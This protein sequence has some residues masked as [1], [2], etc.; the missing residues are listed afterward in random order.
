MNNMQMLDRYGYREKVEGCVCVYNISNERGEGYIFRGTQCTKVRNWKFN[1][2]LY[3]TVIYHDY[4]N[5]Q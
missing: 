3:H 5:N 1:F 2:Q 4:S